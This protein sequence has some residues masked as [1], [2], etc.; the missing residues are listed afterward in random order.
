M[1]VYGLWKLLE[2]SGKPVPLESLE[3]KILAIDVSIWIYQVLQ[4]YQDRHGVPRPNAHLL[5]LFI[6][7]C[8]L[9]YYKIKPIFVFDGGIP[10]LKKNTIALRRKQKSRAMSK[11]QK[12]KADLINNLIKHNVVKTVLN[13]DFKDQNSEAT[14]I[15]INM[16]TKRLEEDMFVLP[17][18]SSANNMQSCNDDDEYDS[19]TLIELSPRKQSKWTGNIHN[20]DV[21]SG[22]FK[23]LPADVRYDILTDLKETRKQNSWGRLHEMPQESQ[24]FSGFQLKRLLKR[25][26][27]QAS[28]ESAEKEMGGKT[29]TLE[30]LDKLLTEQG[31]DTKD[32][33]T[34]FRIAADNTTRLIYISDKNAL[35]QRSIASKLKV[36]KNL[37]QNEEIEPV[38]GPSNLMP[39]IENINEYESYSDDEASVSMRADSLPIA[40]N[41]NEYTFDSDWES[42]NDI[43]ESLA[44]MGKNTMNPALRYML[45]YSDLSQ[46]QIMH[47]IKCNKNENKTANE[48]TKTVA[49]DICIELAKVK[50]PMDDKS[51]LTLSEN[52]EQ[53][54]KSVESHNIKDICAIK[55]DTVDDLISSN[56]ESDNQNQI[57]MNSLKSNTKTLNATIVTDVSTSNGKIMFKECS[58][59]AKSNDITQM[60]MSDTDSDDF[61]EIK[62]VPIHDINVLKNVI[63]MKKDI[64]ITF[65]SDEKLEDDI[66]ADIFEKV[67]KEDVAS[68][69]KQVQSIDTMNNDEHQIQ[70]ISENNNNLKNS[71][72]E[73]KSEESIDKE[74]KFQL[75]EN[76][77]LSENV[78]NDENEI[79][80]IQNIQKLVEQDNILTQIESLDE[81]KRE[82]PAVL[83]TNTKD[84]R[85]LK[86]QLENEQ[87]ELTKDIG[88]LERQAIN[89]SDQI[90][91]DAQELLR[92]FGIPYIVAP[93]EAEAQCAYLEQI[94][95]TDGTI[96]DDSDIWL[97]GGQCV[98]KNFFNNNKKV[99]R[100]RA[101]D[102]QYHFKLS[103]NQLIQLALLVGSDYTTGVAGVGPVTALE[104]LAAFPADGDNLL[105]GLH[106]FCSWVKKGMIATPGKTN[107]RNKLRSMKLDRDFPNQAIVQA[108][109]F[110]MVDE[111]KETFTWGKPNIV[112]LCDYTRQKFGWTKGKFDDMMIPVLRRMEENG[113]QKLLE[114]YFKAKMSPRSIEPILSKRVQKALRRLNNDDVHIDANIDGPKP[115]SKKR[116]NDDTV[117]KLS[118]RKNLV[119][120]ETSTRESEP[121]VEINTIF[122]NFVK[123]TVQGKHTKE[124][125]SQR[126][127]DKECALKRKLHAIEVFRKSKQGLGK[128]RKIKYKIRKIKKQ[129]ELSESDSN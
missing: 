52:C 109:L 86:E 44:L 87:E 62:D 111:S 77:L 39:I 51:V 68:N 65:K 13:K 100:F 75:P 66:F 53:V 121:P 33:D 27:V 40:E 129:A 114:L 85:Q 117:Q 49:K 23:A 59:I 95:L 71:L 81:C 54:L 56:S 83:P 45:E 99:L 19:D 6:R 47:L 60:D 5:G 41:I 37:L 46:N 15:T 9:L 112:L 18:M 26:H 38:A 58:S 29:L 28:L 10:I 31:I 21:T 103:R 91:T 104:I 93:M 118:E 79:Y 122:E 8:K 113:S 116:K 34:A 98:Y 1:G 4:G 67:N 63:T 36:D 126:E 76:V 107:L 92:L 73:T 20:V 24:E 16:Q 30:E 35:A 43:N 90:R 7:I 3:G 89:I 123:Y 2:A 78:S 11:A 69:L 102:I 110:P 82:K 125:I 57:K 105:Q 128:T 120:L 14:Q 42:E 84:L 108:Y 127:K 50:Q 64:E 74:K 106:N 72:L 88:K 101:C 61:I 25:R 32:R 115:Q 48:S 80:D 96:T 12:M 97:F 124:Y 119:Q 70:F 94:K 17:D 22:E 55:E